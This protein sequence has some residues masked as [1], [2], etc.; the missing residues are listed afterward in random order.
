M[1]LVADIRRALALVHPYRN[2]YL[3]GLVALAAVNLCDVLAPLFLTVAIDSLG[4]IV[5]LAPAPPPP[6]LAALGVDIGLGVLG[7]TAAYFALQLGANVFRY[8]MLMQIAVPSHEV[9]QTLRNRLVAHFFE[10]PMAYYDRAKSGDLMSLATADVLAAR[11]MFG[12]GVLVGADA[13]ILVTVVIAVML[14]LSWKLTLIAMAPLP[15]I[16]LFTNLLSHAEYGRFQ[17]VQ[18][19]LATLTERARE[20]FAGLRVLQAY[21]REQFD[22]ARF[23][24]ASER[25]RGLEVRLARV[26]SLFGPTL[27]LMNGLSTALVVIFG[28]RQVVQG[29]LSVGTFVAFLFLIGFLSGPMMGFGW[30]VSLIQ[31]GR[32]SLSRLDAFL[33][34]APPAPLG[35]NAE[36]LDGTGAVRVDGLT[37]AYSSDQPP[38]LRDVSFSI[39]AGRRLGVIGPV[40][41]GKSTLARLLVR[42]YEPPRETVFVDG[43][44]VTD[45]DPDALR[46]HVVLAP[47]DTFLFS[48]TV[49]RNIGLSAR[50]NGK[51]DFFARQSQLHD[52]IAALR[53]GYDTLLGERG[54][55]LSGGQR[56]RLAIARTLAADPRVVVLDDCLSAVDAKTE[57]AILASLDSALEGRT[58]IIISH[59]VCAVRGC[60]EILVLDA[61]GV[62]ARGTHDQLVAADGF[63][64]RIAR[65]QGVDD[66]MTEAH[67]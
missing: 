35:T 43:C 56:Q 24:A 45:A 52:E 46:Q 13:L 58:A 31:R 10:M 25:H 29:T 54:M 8:P 61:G 16:A 41:S 42:L 3:L 26:R 4:A 38:A 7:A 57:E 37:F 66:D 17:D 48:D 27:D 55:T 32:A 59:R 65:E 49:E 21:A 23:T 51:A 34:T 15:L 47:Q 62:A 20:S 39:S 28:G 53:D 11:M 60:D 2:Q 67:E 22:V 30:A 33:E 40:G 12:P 1:A 44:D 50:M 14:T 63:Y 36:A 9:G 64:A 5:G 19:D 6:I 18:K